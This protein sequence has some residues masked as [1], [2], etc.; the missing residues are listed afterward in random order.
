MYFNTNKGEFTMKKKKKK[1][2]AVVFHQHG[3]A[4]IVFGKAHPVNEKHPKKS[5]QKAHDAV[6]ELDKIMMGV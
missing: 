5:T 6:L 3:T 4:K 1:K 2:E